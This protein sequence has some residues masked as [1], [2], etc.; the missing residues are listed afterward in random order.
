MSDSPLPHFDQPATVSFFRKPGLPFVFVRLCMYLILGEGA[1]YVLRPVLRSYLSRGFNQTSPQVIFLAEFLALLGALFAA[2][3]LS[4]LERRGFGEY[5]LSLARN[6]AKH[7][8]QGAAFGIAEISLVL[9]A[10]AAMG[11][12]RFGSLA[13]H[14][15]AIVSWALVWAVVFIAVGLYEEFA[16]PWIRA[17]HTGP[18]DRILASS[19]C[20]IC[21]VWRG[22]LGESGRNSCRDRG[23]NFERCVLVFHATPHRHVVVCHWHARKL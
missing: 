15:K 2:F 12:Y 14:G 9:A 7:C 19:C 18:S 6:S 4:R 13:L 5:G 17:I 8:L 22:P 3:V 20:A 23:S 16:F 10:L 1:A 21:P 11:C